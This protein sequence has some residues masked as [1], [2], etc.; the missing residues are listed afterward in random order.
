VFGF[1]A[2]LCY[3]RVGFIQL[4]LVAAALVAAL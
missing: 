3:R 4:P 1:L 2:F